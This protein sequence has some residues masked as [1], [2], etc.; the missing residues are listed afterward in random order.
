MKQILKIGPGLNNL[1]NTCFCNAVLQCLAHTSPLAN[2]C[3]NRNHSDNLD[4]GDDL[5]DYDALFA[6]ETHIME[7]FGAQQCK[8][9]PPLL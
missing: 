3:L 5:V 2:F 6:V 7:A 8:I 4:I 9:A 1:D